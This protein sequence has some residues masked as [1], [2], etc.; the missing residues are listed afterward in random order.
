MSFQP[1]EK[2]IRYRSMV[3]KWCTELKVSQSL[4][5]A[6]I[7]ME[8]AGNPSAVRYEPEYEKRYILNNA[9]W[10]E[11][12]RSIGISSKEAA[13]SYGLM[14]LMFTT[15]WGFNCRNPKDLFDPNTNIRF[16]TALVAQKLKKFDVK[17]TLCSY[18]GGDG[19]VIKM[20]QG[21]KTAASGYAERGMVLY[22]QYRAWMTQTGK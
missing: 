2:V 21:I 19:S 9:V 6:I 3:D 4:I 10:R 5:L 17:E 16:G 22:N 1:P 12:C 18:N 13:T 20:R 14:Q 11:R 7:Q 15:A 8:S